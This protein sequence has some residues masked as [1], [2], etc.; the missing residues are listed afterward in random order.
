MVST[1]TN[2]KITIRPLKKGKKIIFDINAKLTSKFYM[3]VVNGRKIQKLN[4][5]NKKKKKIMKMKRRIF[6]KIKPQIYLVSKSFL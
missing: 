3:C 1:N 5:Q 2:R 6:H 4:I